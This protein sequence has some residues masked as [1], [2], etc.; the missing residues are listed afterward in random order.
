VAELTHLPLGRTD[1]RNALDLQRRLHALRAAGEIGD[2][3]LTVEHPPVIT[4]GRSGKP[5]HLL[6]SQERLEREG[7]TV[8]DVER[9]GDITYHGPGQLVVYPILDLRDHGRDIKAYIEQLEGA[10]IDTLSSYGISA[11][12]RPGYPG[13]WVGQKKIASIGV[14]VRSW[15]TRHGLALNVEVNPEHFAMINPCGLGVDVVSMADLM[16]SPD[17]DAVEARFLARFGDRL[18]C[19]VVR[20]ELD[21]LVKETA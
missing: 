10:A 2:V 8:V 17:W 15:V 9:G 12:T 4:L 16:N 21:G 19:T 13:V 18:G 3:V 11:E 14:Y 6:V 5:E 7:I 1:Y 20:G